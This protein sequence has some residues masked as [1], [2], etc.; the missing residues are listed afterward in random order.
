M[1]LYFNYNLLMYILPGNT[2]TQHLS[3]S[4]YLGLFILRFLIFISKIFSNTLDI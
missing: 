3:I 1:F 2:S 4:Y